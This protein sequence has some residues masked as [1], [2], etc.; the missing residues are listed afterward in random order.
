MPDFE[1]AEYQQRCLAAQRAMHARKLEVIL[2]CTEVEIRYY[3]GFRTS[4]WL[5][6][7]RP[8]FVLLPLEGMP[9]AI[10]PEIGASL[11]QQ[12]YVGEL[13]TWPSPRPQDE[14]ISLLVHKLQGYRRIGLPMGAGS[15]LRMPLA[16]LQQLQ[17]GLT[18]AEFVDCND[19]IV[20]QRLVKSEAEIAL[21][22]SIC[23]A[24]STAF[25]QAP[26][27][28][29]A[30]QT[31]QDAFRSFRIALLENGAEEVPYLVGGA[32][33]MGYAGVI[34][35]PDETRLQAGDVLMLDTG[36]SLRGY[37][38]DFDRNFAIER[39]SAACARA[40][41]KLWRATEAALQAAR[42][43]ISA[44]QLYGVMQ[45]SLAVN[46]ND[47]DIGRMGHGL[48]MQLTEEPSLMPGDQTVLQ[49][50]MVVTL[51]PSI[52]TAPGLMMVHEE[53]I[54]IT[55]HQ[56]QLLSHRTPPELPVL[57]G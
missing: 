13:L 17:Y 34:A 28:F 7:T 27:L 48:G 18:S 50:G 33:A 32:G 47:I 44:E 20:E 4:F 31:M 29:S 35:P 41:A 9:I 10:V 40:Y 57:G 24:A 55:E 36:A 30:G 38:C 37:F 11:M 5:S 26:K 1:P 52:E 21:I 3:T 49:P 2:L 15:S 8:W 56:P 42:P 25:A 16:D 22:A 53:N 39:A 14:G 45:N 51:E 6:P 54:L 19:L 12:C 43:G 46:G 23:E